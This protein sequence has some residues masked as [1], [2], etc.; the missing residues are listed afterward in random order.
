M[1]GKS[2]THD[3]EALAKRLYEQGVSVGDIIIALK[4]AGFNRSRTS[5]Q[6][7]AENEGWHRTISPGPFPIWN[8]APKLDG[9]WLILSDC[10]VPYHDAEFCNALVSYAL[11]TGIRKV[12]L[13]GDF[14]DWAAFSPFGSLIE[15]E[16]DAE[17]ASASQFIEALCDFDRIVQLTGN[18]EVR[19][20][21]TLNYKLKAEQLL[22]LYTTTVNEQKIQVT[23]YHWCW[24]DTK[25][26][27]WRVTHPR[28]AHMQPCSVARRLTAKHNCHVAVGHDHICGMILTEDGKTWAISTGVCLYPGKLEYISIVDNTRWAVARGALILRDGR[29]ELLTPGFDK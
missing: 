21:R 12:I 17:L 1:P 28:N 18:H 19:L 5:V 16:A 10:H 24:V 15:V 13:N 2:W 25:A 9:D 22:R 6:R 4:G 7:K 11:R 27:R 20:I 23:D 8:D 14:L 26:G 29:P 3:E